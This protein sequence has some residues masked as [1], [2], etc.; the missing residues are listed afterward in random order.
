MFC[1][2]NKR[3]INKLIKG[4]KGQFV[5]EI[6]PIIKQAPNILDFE[7]KRWFFKQGLKKLKV[8]GHG[9]MHLQIRREDIF[10]DSFA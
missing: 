1:L 4:N 7:N 8:Q 9:D 2:R 6:E 5:H 3:V 10:M